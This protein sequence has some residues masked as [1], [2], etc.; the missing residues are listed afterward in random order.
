MA[1]NREIR[2]RNTVI[3]WADTDVCTVRAIGPQDVLDVLATAG[4]DLAGVFA[5]MDEFDAINVNQASKEQLADQLLTRVPDAMKALKKHLPDVLA[6]IIVV[7]SDDDTDGAWEFVRDNFDAALQ[8]YCLAE[9]A[10]LTFVS[11]EGFRTFVG[12]VIA[13]METGRA[14]TVSASR[15]K[16]RSV[17]AGNSSADGRTPS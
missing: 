4:E 7:A 14:L 17:P 6:R 10:R 12:N 15:N 1:I 11:P 5:A 2:K 16:S 8:F 13:L 9:I 3:R